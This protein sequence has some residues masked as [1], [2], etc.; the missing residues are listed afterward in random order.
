MRSMKRL[1]ALS[2]LSIAAWSMADRVRADSI[3]ILNSDFDA[4]TIPTNPGYIDG[5]IDD[6]SVLNPASGVTLT[7]IS[8][9]SGSNTAY[10]FGGGNN[11]AFQTYFFQRVSATAEAGKS[12]ALTADLVGNPSYSD[13]SHGA[14]MAM[15]IGYAGAQG[16]TTLSMKEY[17]FEDLY[18]FTPGATQAFHRKTISTDVIAEND[19]AVG[20]QLYVTFALLNSSSGNVNFFIDNVQF[21]SSSIPEPGTFTL[22]AVGLTGLMAYAW[23]RQK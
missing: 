23:R 20:R 22:L 9:V 5:V 7:T 17:A 11:T 19:G 12:Y 1:W 6:W 18:D 2:F 10:L 13:S 8:G 21:S 3:A 4:Q 15:L 14:I 16:D